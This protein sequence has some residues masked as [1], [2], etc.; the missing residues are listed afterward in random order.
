MGP[1]H[2]RP[3]DLTFITFSFLATIKLQWGRGI[4]APETDMVD[5]G[6]P[7]S[8]KRLQWGRGIFA[9]ETRWLML[10]EV[11]VIAASMGP[12]HFRPGDCRTFL[13]IG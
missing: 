1:G 8:A 9:P 5:M 7:K 13:R 4:F 10:Y 6:I 12:G 2:F 3:G 11:L